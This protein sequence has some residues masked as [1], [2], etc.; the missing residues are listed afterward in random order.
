M[1]HILQHNEELIHQAHVHCD[2]FNEL[3]EQIE[4]LSFEQQLT[5]AE[6]MNC[7]IDK[8]KLDSKFSF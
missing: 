2:Q 7:D 6:G 8:Q 3:T 5:S 4:N 1:E